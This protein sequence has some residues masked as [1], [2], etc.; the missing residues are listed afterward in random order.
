MSIL[1]ILL[2]CQVSEL[3][4]LFPSVISQSTVDINSDLPGFELKGSG[5]SELWGSGTSED[6]TSTHPKNPGQRISKY[7][8][9]TPSDVITS[10]HFGAIGLWRFLP[11]TKS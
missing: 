8:H 4:L 6:F 1:S 3:L 5:T 2:E 11:P 10:R 9:I 7:F